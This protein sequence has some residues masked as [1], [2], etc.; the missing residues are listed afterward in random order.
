MLVRV[1]ALLCGLL[2]GAA[3]AAA[4]DWQTF[5]NPEYGVATSMPGSPKVSVDGTPA[6]PNAG[7]DGV[8]TALVV[9]TDTRV[10]LLQASLYGAD[11]SID[12]RVLLNYTVDQ[13]STPERGPV[14][15][16]AETTVQGYP[17]I[18]VVFGPDADGAFIR[19]RVIAR[20]GVLV[21]LITTDTSMPPLDRFYTDFKILP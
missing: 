9:V 15:Y 5:A 4:A 18:D 8:L 14:A 12:P 7:G 10:Y 3:P 2:L 20:N 17:A 16:R 6:D 1:L 11:P 13:V 19:D 21:Q